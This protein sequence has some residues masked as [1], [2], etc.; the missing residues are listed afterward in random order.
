MAV[1]NVQTPNGI[2]KIEGP[3]DA[4]DEELIQA[5]QSHVGAQERPLGLL[6]QVKVQQAEKP[7]Y[8]ASQYENTL[9]IANPFGENFNTGIPVSGSIETWLA[10]TGKGLSDTVRGVGQHLGLVSQDD[11]KERAKLDEALMNTT[12][13]KVGNVTGHVAALAPAMFVPGANTYGGAATIGAISGALAPVEEGDLLTGSLKSGVQGAALGVA[14]QKI[15]NVIGDGVKTFINSRTAKALADESRNSVKDATLKA[16]IDAGYVA[17]P[18]MM[19][20]GVVPRMLEGLSGKYK[21]NQLAGIRN[22]DVTDALARKAVG[23]ADDAPLTSEAMQSIRREAYNSGYQPVASAGQ[24]QTDQIFRDSLDSLIANHQGASRSFPGAISNDVEGAIS[25][26]KVSGFDAG[27]ALKATQILRDEAGQAFRN[28]D[29]AMGNAKK[30]A[31]NAIEDQIE[32]GLA[33][34]GEDGTTLLKQFREARKLMAKAHTV[35]A[36]IKEGGG[37]VDA[38]KL[39]A[40]VQAGK[41]MTGELATI[42]NFANNFKDVARVP[43]SGHANPFTIVDFGVGGA[44]FGVNPLLT[45]LPVARVA[46]RY[47]VLSKSAQKSMAAKSYSPGLLANTLKKLPDEDKLKLLITSG[48]LAGDVSQ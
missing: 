11:L 24:I 22:Q 21:T 14:G 45:A 25:G 39:A 34:A 31:A 35:E 9:Q 36:A 43:Q 44:G 33:S 28:G 20:S 41:P 18:S 6:E 38:M 2:V 8:D 5:A 27:D 26:Y 48:L 30:G 13:G 15:G 16:A 46:A 29:T 3:D 1:F 12:A 10:G 23:L 37:S 17:P 7:K 19:G 4:T 40:R 32:R 47:G 42:G